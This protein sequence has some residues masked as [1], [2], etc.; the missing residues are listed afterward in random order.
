MRQLVV[1]KNVDMKAEISMVLVAISKQ[2]SEK[3]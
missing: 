1:G 3:T 2:L